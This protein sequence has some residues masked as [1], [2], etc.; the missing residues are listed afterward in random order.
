MNYR[1]VLLE[2]ASSLWHAVEERAQKSQITPK[3]IIESN[4]VVFVRTMVSKTDCIG[5][6]PSHSAQLSAEAGDL[7][8]DP[9]RK[10]HRAWRAAA[11]VATHGSRPFCRE[12]SDRGGASAAAQH[13]D[14]LPRTRA[15]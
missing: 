4:S 9:D 2:D 7:V 13:H 3:A 15:S 14:R 1:W 6:L 12:Q 5:V 11:T 10:A 8:S